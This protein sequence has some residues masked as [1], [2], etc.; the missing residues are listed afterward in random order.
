MKRAPRT[1]DLVEALRLPLGQLP[2]PLPL[3]PPP[4][5]PAQADIT[6]PGSKSLTNRTILL[7]AL[8]EGASLI[9]GV[10]LD[11]EDAE[12]MIEGVQRLGAVVQRV[13][14]TLH[15]RGVGG[16]W[17]VGTEG[18]VLDL[19]NAGTAT[20]F[21]AAAALLSPGPVTIDGSSRMRD[22]PIGELG[23]ILAALGCNVEYLGTPGC[24]P[25][26]IT[27]PKAGARASGVLEIGET[28]S[29]QFISALL[30][31]SP[32]LGGG[33]VT[34]RLTGE[35]TSPPYI[36]MTL[37]LLAQLGAEVRS[38]DDLR[39]LRV[40]SGA[41]IGGRGGILP[42]EHDVE[43]DASGATYWWGAGAL[44]AG[45][46]VRVLGLGEGALQGDAQF[47]DLLSRMGC[48]ITRRDSP[49]SVEVGAA[50]HLKPILADMSEMPDAAMTLGVVAAFATG[51]SIMRGLR[52]LRVKESDRVAALKTELT[53]LGAAVESPLHADRDAM[54]IT[55]GGHDSRSPLV[56]DTYNDH[57]MAMSLALV[58]LRRANVS[59]RNPACV[60]KT[61][62]E[63]W[64]EFSRLFA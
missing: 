21:L 18:V 40:A 12:V 25:L 4:S 33:G 39:V 43:P 27:P 45:A 47:P 36:S 31:V 5:R 15:V 44:L 63:F 41:S 49:D 2:D 64:R 3:P 17:R 10:P 22:R 60:G 34:L 42:F 51:T 24:P 56:F 57:R 38:S 19:R 59:I 16:R 62:P 11:A 6:P 61:Y 1:S 35:V 29:S 9:R 28:R 58:G 30:L 52:T 32:W 37:A 7:A 20:R 14:T 23:G 48:R 46:S 26:R 13:G 50:D 55:P 54:T 8:A 53:K